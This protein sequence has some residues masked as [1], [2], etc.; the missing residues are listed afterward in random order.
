MTL[1]FIPLPTRHGLR[2]V[3]PALI[4]MLDTVHGGQWTH[5]WLMGEQRPIEVRE[6]IEEVALRLG[7]KL[8]GV[9]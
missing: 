5:I 4:T 6:P 1:S 8:R 3:N 2:W 9:E 7:A